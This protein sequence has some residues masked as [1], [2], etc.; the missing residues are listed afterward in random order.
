[1][2]RALARD[3]GLEVDSVVRKGKNAE[4]QDTFLVQAGAGRAPALLTGFPSRREDLYAYD[5]LVI[6][7]VEGDFFTRAQLAMAADFVAERGGGLLVLGGRSFTSRGLIGTPLEDVLPVELNDRRGAIVRTSLGG[8]DAGAGNKLAV[9]AEGENHPIMRIGGSREDTLKLWAGMPALAASAP[10]G[11]PRPGATVL[12]VTQSPGGAVH[13]GRR[14]AAVRPGPLDDL[15]GRSLVAMEDAARVDRSDARVL[16]AP[17]RHGGSRGRRRIRSPSPCPTRPSPGDSIAVDVD[18]RDAAFAPVADASVEATLTLPGGEARTL[19]LRR[20]GAAGARFT[21]AVRVDRPGL[22][23]V[24]AEARRGAT[25]LGTADRWFQVGGADREFA[26]P[27]L[28]EGFLRRVARASGGRYVRAGEA[29]RIVSWLQDARPSNAAPEQTRSLAHA[30]GLRVHHRAALGGVDPAP[31]LGIEMIAPAAA[32]S[33]R[34]RTSAGVGPPVC[35]IIAP[36]W[37]RH[38]Q[39][40]GRKFLGR[41][42]GLGRGVWP[43]RECLTLFARSV[44]VVPPRRLPAITT[45]S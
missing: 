19:K 35:G 16:L 39:R 12:A 23:R 33:T 45:R 36:G 14:G 9:T 1:M 7:N 18:A 31:P 40:L 30:L 10:L 22:Y 11:G 17:G 27:R 43:C 42:E 28:N 44:R 32:P 8:R 41:V 6:A 34:W 20:A 5:A 25:P 4:G 37:G 24:R 13:P 29:G 26:D 21:A 2:K 3:P 15:R 38:P